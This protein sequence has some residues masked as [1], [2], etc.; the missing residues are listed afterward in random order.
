MNTDSLK[1]LAES[2]GAPE[3]VP[4]LDGCAGYTLTEVEDLLHGLVAIQGHPSS[5]YRARISTGLLND[6][7]DRVYGFDQAAYVR[8]LILDRI[9]QRV[10]VR[11]LRRLGQELWVLANLWDAAGS[12]GDLDEECEALDDGDWA[13]LREACSQAVPSLEAVMHTAGRA[14][15]YATNGDMSGMASAHEAID[16]FGWEL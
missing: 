1:A 5:T 15:H 11:G 4:F 9:E 10:R 2:A 14:I 16:Y 3:I 6:I 13:Y 12:G 7:W 8:W